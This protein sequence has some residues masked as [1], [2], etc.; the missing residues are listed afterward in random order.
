MKLFNVL[1]VSISFLTLSLTLSA[2]EVERK[3]ARN[4]QVI[5]W[6]PASLLKLSGTMDMLGNPKISR[7]PHGNAVSFNGSDDALILNE[8]PL[9]NMQ[10]FTIE[11]IFK[12]DT[13]SPFEQRIVHI[14][15]VSGDRVLLEIRAVKNKWYFDGFAASGQNKKALIDSTLTH[16]LGIWHHVAFIVEPHQIS[17]YVNKRLECKE[18]FNFKPIMSGKTSLGMRLNKRSFFKGS[19]FKVRVTEGVLT[20]RKFMK[21]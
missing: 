6:E 10:S 17:T 12:P 3:S 2:Q 14:G 11:M 16:P 7:S 5:E 19:I 4:I 13:A 8:M 21:I 1:L 15:E 9:A 18:A 20:P